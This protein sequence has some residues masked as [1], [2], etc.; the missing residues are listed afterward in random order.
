[1]VKHQGDA[2]TNGGPTGDLYIHIRVSGSKKFV[3]R[4]L[5][6]ISQLEISVFDAILGGKFEVETFW[7]KMELTVPENTKD[8]SLLR[9]KNK[10]VKTKD[11]TTGDHLVK[12]FHTFPKKINKKMREAIESIK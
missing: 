11:G 5:D 3:R 2:G 8:E 12:I 10:G 4:K 9:I 7:G 1:M 6:I